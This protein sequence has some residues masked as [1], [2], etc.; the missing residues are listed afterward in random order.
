MTDEEYIEEPILSALRVSP[1]ERLAAVVSKRATLIGN[2]YKWQL[3]LWE[4]ASREKIWSEFL[5]DSDVWWLNES[6]WLKRDEDGKWGIRGNISDNLKIAAWLEVELPLPDKITGIKILEDQKWLLR[7]QE[8]IPQDPDYYETESLPFM[9]DGK[10]YISSFETLYLYEADK[11]QLHRLLSDR[12]EVKLFGAGQNGIWFTGY[13]RDPERVD[14]LYSGFYYIPYGNKNDASY[15]FDKLTDL[16]MEQKK[17]IKPQVLIED[18]KIRIDAVIDT[19][20]GWLLAAS[21]ME[22]H[23]PGQSPDFLHLTYD[24]ELKLFAEND[25][26]A[27]HAV[28]RDWKGTGKQFEAIPNG[29]AY[30]STSHGRVRINT[31]TIGTP[32]EKTAVSAGGKIRCLLEEPGTIDA[33]HLFS[34]GKI[35]TVGAYE[36]NQDELY[37]YEDKERIQISHYHEKIE[38][39]KKSIF[40]FGTGAGEG[41]VDVCVLYP[42]GF[43]AADT[44]KRY[45]AILSIHGGHKLSYG[46]DVLNVDFK[47]WTDEGYFVIYCNPRGS[48]GIDD[49][50]ADIIGKNGKTDAADIMKALDLVLE[51]EKQ[52]DRSRIGVT[53]GSYGG[54]LTNFLIT[55]TDRFACAVSV[56]S[57][58]N[59]ISKELDSDMGYR[60]PIASLGNRV[61]RESEAF[62]EASPIK[63]IENCHTP[64]LIIHA[65][66]DRRCPVAEGI[67]MYTA[68]KLQN[69]PA[70][71]IL[72]SGESH[73]LAISG[74]PRARL[75]HSRVI[76]E[77]FSRYLK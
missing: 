57:I 37:I 16:P 27:S 32:G 43:D 35:L 29:I 71:L 40:S 77:W 4:I 28:V 34:D 17:E 19:N 65:E 46:A 64:T 1:D 10:G 58:S 76:R 42:A 15:L 14:F 3:D 72:F 51:R 54:Y 5:C 12:Y 24:G 68:L 61:W 75:K 69:V 26:S 62:W 45:P 56:R 66:G 73:G 2:S 47:L 48:E 49:A 44:A 30:L 9:E 38:A 39:P 22:L 20:D 70:K 53:G 63:Y 36:W 55:Q 59:R 8:S 13:E 67:Q 6:T 11:R 33:F 7:V 52:I 23:G 31:C 21:S 41:K 50:F 18:G 25:S 60:Y 74:K